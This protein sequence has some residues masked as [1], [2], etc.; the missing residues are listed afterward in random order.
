MANQR[1]ERLRGYL[2]EVEF[3]LDMGDG[4]FLRETRQR[5]STLT[6]NAVEQAEMTRLDAFVLDRIL[7]DDDIQSFL[8]DDA[9]QEPLT[10]WW[11]HLGKLRAGTYPAQLLPD[12]LRAIY[13]PELER[14]AA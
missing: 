1:P 5:L 10:H 6:L 13:Q 14:L 11:W 12:H 4:P 8:F 7:L 3:A 2:E 9:T